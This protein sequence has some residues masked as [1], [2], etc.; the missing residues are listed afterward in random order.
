MTPGQRGLIVLVLVATGLGGPVRLESSQAKPE[1]VLALF[2]G[3][4]KTEAVIRNV[5][6]SSGERRTLGR[7]AGRL[8]ADGRYVEF[9]TTSLDPPGLAEL[10]VMTWD[11]DAGIYRQWV[12]DTDGY[13]HEAVGRWDPAT[14]TLRW[15]GQADG[16]TFV[17]DDR[18][19][20]RDRLEWR[21]TRT[22]AD[23]RVLQTIEGVV[24]R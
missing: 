18:W 17:I 5:G 15:E 13:R 2:V 3:V 20:S 19:V 7:A 10:Q 22:S 12:S 1:A 16:A 4:W 6:A 11:P 21:L 8:I 14:S 23:G 24:S 9:R